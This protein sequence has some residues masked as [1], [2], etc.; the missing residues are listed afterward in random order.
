[1]NKF[2]VSIHGF[3]KRSV[4]ELLKSLQLE[5]IKKKQTLENQLKDILANIQKLK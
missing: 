1:M 4:D 3:Q 5:H 2:K